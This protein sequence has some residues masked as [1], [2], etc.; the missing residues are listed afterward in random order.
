MVKLRLLRRA[1]SGFFGACAEL[2]S[3]SGDTPR[4]LECCDYGLPLLDGVQE[5]RVLDD[6]VFF[7]DS[8]TS[9]G[10]VI[11]SIAVEIVNSEQA[12]IVV[13]SFFAADD[14]IGPD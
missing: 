5:S 11:Q 9:N 14:G 3:Q 7:T 4:L 2:C 12:L 8:L 10:Y 13:F 1:E 6:S